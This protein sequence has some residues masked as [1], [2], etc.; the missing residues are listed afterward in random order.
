MI[1]YSI[2]PPS[3]QRPV[4]PPPFNRYVV[5]EDAVWTEFYRLGTGYLLRFP[6]LAD[7]EVST[8]GTVVVAR[9]AAGTD[10]ATIEHLYLNQLVPLALSR[11]GRPAFHASVVSVPGGC[12][13][14]L[15]ASGMGKSTLAASFALSGAAFLTDDALIVDDSGT[16]IL[17]MPS[18]ASLRLWEDSVE[19]LVGP[20]TV[21]AG[22]VS[23]SDKA[24]LLAGPGLAHGAAPLPLQAAYLLER[25]E[26][27]EITIKPLAGSLRHIA[28]IRNSFLLDIEDRDLLARHFDWTH[29]I[30]ERVPTY[31]LDYARDYGN[32]AQVRARL[33]QHVGTL[34]D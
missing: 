2:S 9:P 13:A 28:W 22:G 4:G 24:R 25:T 30:A 6:G 26:P 33:L 34:Q 29:R 17:A 16:E 1:R 15:G 7:F 27:A 10:A 8:D 19:A 32:L 12:I 31:S 18:H 3:E 20:D 5:G 23:F 21:R 14:F 11:Q